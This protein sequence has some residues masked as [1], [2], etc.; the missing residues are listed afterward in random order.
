MS[1]GFMEGPS[2]RPPAMEF[3][4]GRQVEIQMHTDCSGATRW[5]RARCEV[6]GLWAHQARKA[7]EADDITE[8]VTLREMTDSGKFA[9]DIQTLR[10]MDGGQ[11]N[12]F[13]RWILITHNTVR[14]ASETSQTATVNKKGAK[15]QTDG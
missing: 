8:L 7:G 4:R 6:G 15:G 9:N 11:Q 10:G 2:N 5:H 1:E 12:D 13:T 14:V 3:V